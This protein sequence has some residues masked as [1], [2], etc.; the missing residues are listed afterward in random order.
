MSNN[1]TKITKQFNFKMDKI[2][3]WL[4][5]ASLIIFFLSMTQT[6]GPIWVIILFAYT[7]VVFVYYFVWYRKKP[8]YVIVENGNQHILV[9][10]P[11]FFKPYEFE[12]QQ[13]EQ[14]IVTDKKIEINYKVEG[15]SKSVSIY[16][17]MLSEDDWKQLPIILKKPE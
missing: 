6:G 9:H 12:K 16:S 1:S 10:I 15:S 17:I 13:I 2:E 8:S 5:I 7:I 11:P 4:S 3:K 14:V